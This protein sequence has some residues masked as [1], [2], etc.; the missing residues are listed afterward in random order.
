MNEMIDTD[1]T[2]VFPDSLHDITV[3]RL[4]IDTAKA[5]AF[6][7]Q[8]DVLPYHGRITAIDVKSKDDNWTM[9]FSLDDRRSGKC[10]VE[11]EHRAW[12]DAG[13]LTVFELAVHYCNCIRPGFARKPVQRT[14]F[15]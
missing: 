8:L 11:A 10:I 4:G 5:E 9:R 13:L 3:A 12:I 15:D 7:Q 2:F 14:L 6:R 1:R